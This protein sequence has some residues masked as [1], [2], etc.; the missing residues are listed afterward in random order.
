MKWSY[1]LGEWFGIAVNVHATF[2][3]LLGWIALG[4]YADAH[5]PAAVLRSVLFTLALFC[6]VVLH[7]Y[8]HALTAR[9]FGIRTRHI[10]LYPIGGVAL[11]EGMPERPREQLLVALAGPA[12]NFAL[13]ATVVGAMAV[14]GQPLGQMTRLSWDPQSLLAQLFMANI[15]MGAFNLL[16]ALPMDGGRVLRAL[17][18]MRLGPVSAT[19]IAAGVAKLVALTMGAYGFWNEVPMLMLIAVV[20]WVG[21]TA[22]SRMAQRLAQARSGRSPGGP[23]YTTEVLPVPLGEDDHAEQSHGQ[24]VRGDAVRSSAQVDGVLIELVQTPD[25]PRMRY[26]RLR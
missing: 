26:S 5:S 17:L 18:A 7:E 25:G 16:P 3:L 4:A 13:A 11:L 8:G 21:S 23:P 20:V 15:L 12:V 19:R 1:K 10:T 24:T 22:E 6:L 9:H 14:L 2:L